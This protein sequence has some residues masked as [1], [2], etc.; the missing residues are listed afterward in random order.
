MPI[1]IKCRRST[2]M[3]NRGLISARDS[4]NPVDGSD[5]EE[6][7][8]GGLAATTSDHLEHGCTLWQ[9]PGAAQTPTSPGRCELRAGR[10]ASAEP[11]T[12]I[13]NR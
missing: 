5:Y 3:A 6:S 13:V 8:V 2:T 7:H 11:V 10:H 4:A 9:G 1:R 12:Q